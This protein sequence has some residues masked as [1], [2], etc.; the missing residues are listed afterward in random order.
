MKKAF[1]PNK[2][3]LN[4][5]KVFD[6]LMEER[7]VTRAAQ[8]TSR[9][10]SAVSHS[11]NKLRDIFGDELFVNQ[12]G[13]MNPTALAREL[14]PVI[15]QALAD[16]QSVVD[17]N[18]DFKPEESTRK[19]RVGVT[20]YTGALYLPA[21]LARFG[22]QAPNA[23]LQIIPILVYD[24]AETL[25]AL[26]LDALLIGNPVI[27]GTH[28]VE[29]V[30][31]RHEMLC[32]AWSGNRRIDQFNLETYLS[33]PHLQISPD[34][35]E[36]GVSDK[37]LADMGLTRRVT[38]VI[39][40]YMVAPKVLRGTDMIA[41]FADGMLTLLDASSE[42]RVMPPPFEMPSVRVSL[43]FARSRQA[44]AGHIWL[45]SC[46]RAVVS[47]REAHKR[48]IIDNLGQ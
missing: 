3:D 15:A 12:A 45:R 7:S 30:L 33:L 35:D 48:T 27:K 1:N 32:A 24:A 10:Q 47:A 8:R 44:D 46:I 17:R 23:R 11:L 4:L 25:A 29:T 14:G 5:L 9:T 19:F 40:H 21:L 31:A 2:V 39:P 18:I 42:I 41:A 20:D 13:T 16:L 28:L 6:L 22:R 37:A 43:V 34:G 38:A 26:E 36:N